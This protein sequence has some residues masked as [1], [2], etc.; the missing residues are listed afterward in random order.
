MKKSCWRKTIISF[1]AGIFI[2]TTLVVAQDEEET[3]TIFTI[4]HYKIK[5]DMIDDYMDY[6]KE[7]RI[8]WDEVDEI[9]SAQVLRHW[10]AG[11]WNVILIWEWESL[12]QMDAG[13]KH[14]DE[15][16]KEKYPNKV[17]RERRTKKA[18][19][20]ILDH[21]DDICTDVPSLTK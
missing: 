12:S 19:G 15:V 7:N 8:L 2:L 11:N 4:S 9:L 5:Y 14:L 16:M 17:S 21:W 6:L 20:M 1:F 13:V 10:W 3:G 18:M